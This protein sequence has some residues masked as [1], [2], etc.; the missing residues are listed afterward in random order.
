MNASNIKEY[1]SSRLWPWPMFGLVVTLA[2][3]SGTLYADSRLSDALSSWFFQLD[4][5]TGDPD[6]ARTI[7]S[8]IAGS[9]VTLLVFTFTT[10]MVIIQLA[11]AQYSP[12][13]TR[14]VLRDGITKLGLTLFIS[15]FVY[16]LVVMRAVSEQQDVVYVPELSLV[17]TYLLVVASLLVFV[18]YINHV[19]HSMRVGTVIER[20]TRETR[21]LIETWVDHG[22]RASA[23]RWHLEGGQTVACSRGGAISHI[24]E[25]ALLELASERDWVIEILYRM[26]D[27]VPTAAPIARVIGDDVDEEAIARCITLKTSRTMQQ[28][29]AYGLR[30]LVDI[31]NRALSPGINDPTTA[32]QCVDGLHEILRDLL[33][34]PALPEAL[35]DEDGQR[36]LLIPRIQ[37]SEYLTL[38][39]TEIRLS[40]A[41]S[42]QIPR[43]LRAM[44]LDLYNV[45]P[46]EQRPLIERQL[47]LLEASVDAEVELRADRDLLNAPDHQGLGG[48]LLAEH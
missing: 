11:S 13:L 26:G 47:Q 22:R 33:Q 16:A 38:A 3:A 24:D 14:S 37:W 46:V 5:I 7:L 42:P 8:V 1:T 44:L 17:A 30:Q 45:A 15:T 32:L 9:M 12:R 43:R 39:T 19:A 41:S 18:I 20:V 48:S 31:A 23:K 35:A 36:R 40:G 28:D 25:D 2:I 27:H 4:L 6:S 29:V 10:T 34:V 21:T